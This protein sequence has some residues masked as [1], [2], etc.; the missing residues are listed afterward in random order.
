MDKSLVGYVLRVKHFANG[1]M[2]I[3]FV[4]DDNEEL[5]LHYDISKHG[6]LTKDMAQILAGTLDSNV[7]AEVIFDDTGIATSIELE[8]ISEEDFEES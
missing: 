2:N 6:E 8:V 3:T 4:T 1:N 5:E 7:W